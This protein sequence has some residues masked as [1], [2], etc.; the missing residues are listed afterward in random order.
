MKITTCII[1][2]I[3]SLAFSYNKDLHKD[4]KNFIKKTDKNVSDEPETISIINLIASPEKYDRKKVRVIGYLTLYF[5][6]SVLYLHKVD[7]DNM[8][9]KNGIWVDVSRAGLDSLKSYNKHYV[10]MDGTF[11]S[12]RKG[13][14]DMNSGNIKN[15]TRLDLW[16]P[17]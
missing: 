13:H 16:P 9:T 14:M 11:D 17:K 5:E 3:S 4:K 12:Q 15:I 7:F 10:I 8:I 2:L 1:L 6:S